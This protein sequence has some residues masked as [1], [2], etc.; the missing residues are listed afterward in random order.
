MKKLVEI[1][2]QRVCQLW[3]WTACWTCAKQRSTGNPADSS[4]SDVDFRVPRVLPTHPQDVL[5]VFMS[6]KQ[7]YSC[8]L[9]HRWVLLCMIFVPSKS[10]YIL[11][12]VQRINIFRQLFFQ[13]SLK[14]SIEKKGD[15]YFRRVELRQNW[16]NQ[17]Q[18]MNSIVRLP[19]LFLPLQVSLWLM[20]DPKSKIVYEVKRFT[21]QITLH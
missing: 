17:K 6:T 20:K 2:C 14:T 7:D 10:D 18:N 13:S 21:S 9:M 12:T 19:V 4:G 8:F 16:T 15:N 1:Y 11:H 3:Q 5:R